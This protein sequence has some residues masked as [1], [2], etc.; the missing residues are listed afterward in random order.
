VVTNLLAVARPSRQPGEG[1]SLVPPPGGFDAREM[2][3][4]LLAV[5]GPDARRR[6]VELV[7]EF[8]PETPRVRARESSVRQ[9]VFQ[10][11]LNAIEVT[12]ERGEVRLSTG[13]AAASADGKAG[14][15]SRTRI[16]VEDTGPGLP[17]DGPERVFDEFFTTKPGGTGLGLAIAKEEIERAGGT[18]EA[19]PR[20]D[21]NEGARFVVTLPAAK[22]AS[23]T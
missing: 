23:P 17:A 7:T 19:G 15:D 5:L 22:R 14:E 16:V 8:A 1:T 20:L 11:L 3:E 21:D 13:P 9:A 12:P 10:L 6:G 18:V 2:L 4:G